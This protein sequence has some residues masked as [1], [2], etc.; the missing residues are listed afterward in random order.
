MDNL[1]GYRDLLQDIEMW[2]IRMDDL[3]EERRRLTKKMIQPPA[4]RLCANYTG[5]PG[6]GYMVINL[7]D[8]WARIQRIDQ[9]IEECKEILSLKYEHKQRM[10]AVMSQMDKIENRVAYMRDVQG[11]KLHEI[12]KEV[13][14]SEGYV[15]QIS[16]R[17]PRMRVKIPS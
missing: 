10:E 9:Q 4:T 11:K 1:K 15:R 5:M 6:A 3:K 13:H 2:T 7:P 12:A 17:V 14:L 8:Y 16:M